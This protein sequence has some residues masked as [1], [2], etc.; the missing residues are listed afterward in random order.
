[1]PWRKFVP[2]DDRVGYDW[3]GF[4]TPVSRVEELTG[5]KFFDKVPARLIEHLKEE[6][7]EVPIPPP[8][9]PRHNGD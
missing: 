5:Y 1:L 7:D 9:P 4:R 3:A 2:N 6:H 8:V